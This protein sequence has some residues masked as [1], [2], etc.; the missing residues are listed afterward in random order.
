MMQFKK[1]EFRASK[2]GKKW[3]KDRNGKAKSSKKEGEVKNDN[4]VD[5]NVAIDTLSSA[6]VVVQKGPNHTANVSFPSYK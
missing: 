1:E 2:T 6:S 4:A 3:K 5:V